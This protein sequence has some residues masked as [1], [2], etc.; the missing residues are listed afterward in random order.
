MMQ[1]ASE[2]PAESTTRLKV[3]VAAPPA[4]PTPTIS[5]GDAALTALAGTALLALAA[6]KKLGGGQGVKGDGRGDA[7]HNDA[8]GRHGRGGSSYDR[9]T[10]DPVPAWARAP[11]KPN[12]GSGRT[13]RGSGSAASATAAMGPSIAAVTAKSHTPYVVPARGHGGGQLRP[14]P[15]LT[16]AAASATAEGGFPQFSK[17]HAAAQRSAVRLPTFTTTAAV[18]TAPVRPPAPRIG[19]DDDGLPP[20]LPPA[21]SDET[22]RKRASLENTQTVYEAGLAAFREHQ[23]ARAAAA[24]ASVQAP[25][26]APPSNEAMDKMKEDT[27]LLRTQVRVRFPRGNLSLSQSGR[28]GACRRRHD[29]S[30]CSFLWHAR[31]VHREQCRMGFNK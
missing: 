1:A 27:A 19:G 15:A 13:R 5:S 28:P 17:H 29:G 10:P 25:N 3:S 30:G 20:P 18:A 14:A 12:Q 26:G 7:N 9:G 6:F 8:G 2:L 4:M 21:G 16:A 31:T 23:A 24:A 22:I 11:P